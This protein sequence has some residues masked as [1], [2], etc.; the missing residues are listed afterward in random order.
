[1][2]LDEVSEHSNDTGTVPIAVLVA[3]VDEFG[4]LLVHEII[5]AEVKLV[6]H[7]SPSQP[8]S[9]SVHHRVVWCPYVPESVKDNGNPTLHTPPIVL[10]SDFV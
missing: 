2:E 5:G 1:M 8:T 4:H 10:W 3:A 7:V 9:S 6:L